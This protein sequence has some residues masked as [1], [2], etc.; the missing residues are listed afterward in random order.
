MTDPRIIAA[1]VT[2]AIDEMDD[3]CV[4]QEAQ[5]QQK[6]QPYF[7]ASPMNLD[8]PTYRHLLGQ[9]WAFHR[10]RCYLHG[11]RKILQEQSP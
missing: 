10:M 8:D 7:E 2:G 9:N 1:G 4:R 11:S 3:W 5:L 6:M